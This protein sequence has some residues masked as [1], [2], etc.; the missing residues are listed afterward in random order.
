VT[1]RRTRQIP[2]EQTRV[3]RQSILRAHESVEQLAAHEPP[4]AYA[5]GAFERDELLAVG[6]VAPDGPPGSWRVR[7]MATVAAARGRGLGG[8]VLA[9]LVEHAR[10][11]GAARVWCNART[12]ARAFYERAGFRVISEEFEIAPIGSHYVMERSPS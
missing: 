4:D 3:L 9:A 5:V 11:H 1:A 2:I 7:A 8:A 6:F 12:P 10:E